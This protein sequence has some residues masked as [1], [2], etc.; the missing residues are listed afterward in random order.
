M[1]VTYKQGKIM[2]NIYKS[3]ALLCMGLAATACIEENFENNGP[4][5]D[6]TPG[7]EIVF[8]ATTGVED[9]DIKTRTVYGNSELTDKENGTGQQGLIEVNWIEGDMISIVSPQA[10]GADVAHFEVIADDDNIND[11]QGAHSAK[12]LK[13]IGD[14]GLQW[15]DS[16]AFDFYAV[17]PTV[18]NKSN[19]SLTKEGVF[20]GSL[21]REQTFI[22]NDLVDAVDGEGNK[23]K[24]APP[25]MQYAFMTAVGNY[26]RPEEGKSDSPINLS[27]SS[28]MTALQFDVTAGEI[29]NYVDEVTK[30]SVKSI[31]IVSISLISNSN[32][33]YGSFEYDFRE[34]VGDRYRSTT[35]GQGSANRIIMHF[36]ETP[37]TLEPK[38]FLDVT[39]FLLPE[40]I[41]A[42]DLTLQII[43]KLG[44]T[45]MS[46]SAVINQALLGGKKYRFEDVK[47]EDFEENINAGS[48]FDTID[49]STYLSQLSI[50]VASN[51]F[52]TKANGFA[53]K[54]L[55]QALDLDALWQLGVR[56]FELV[57][58]RTV[59]ITT[60][61][62]QKRYS[63]NND[64]S[65]A[66]AHFVCD[67]V[68]KE[69][70][71][72][73]GIDTFGEAFETLIAKL[74]ANPKEFLAIIC[75]YQ[76]IN[77]GYDPNGYVK[78]LLNYLDGLVSSKKV[79]KNRFIKIT[80]ETTVADAQGSIAIIIRPGDDDRYETNSYTSGISLESTAG[81]DWSGEV[82]L[83]QDWGTAFD[84]WDR[85]YDGVARESTFETLYVVEKAKKSTTPRTQIEDWLWGVGS[86]A[87]G[88]FTVYDTSVHNFNSGEKM[89]NKKTQFNYEHAITGSTGKAYVQEWARVAETNIKTYVNKEDNG[90][91]M[92]V[93]W[94]ES[95]TDKKKAID[96]LFMQSVATLGTSSNN[97]YIN[98]LSGYYIAQNIIEGL[99]PFKEE[100]PTGRM[101]G[102]FG[103]TPQYFSVSNQGKGGEHQK[104]AYDLNKYV[105]EILSGASNLTV[106]TP[107]EGKLSQ[108]PWGLVMME[109]IGSDYAQDDMSIEL[110]D[111]IIMNNFKLELD[112]ADKTRTTYNATYSNGGEAISFK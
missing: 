11:F 63:T 15:S 54:S 108:G 48:W 14:A 37:V 59:E 57:N 73:A 2:K 32:N 49:P 40:Q 44:S 17:Y 85:R 71:T 102:L 13:R 106:T 81:E 70:V 80:D 10:A 95:I 26:T 28:L 110:V 43:F 89:P 5:Y 78:Q 96:G 16:P 47:L 93:D 62:G 50:P 33:I 107:Q 75:T 97:L 67:E 53:D 65:L 91:Y 9:N 6:T 46:R 12:E 58:R 82:T 34:E 101:G 35:T 74:D 64:W 103:N 66:N 38:Q 7:N 22:G 111:L 77:D 88:D 61:W 72:D 55:Q 25:N 45:T 3:F 90:R 29:T 51:V 87:T 112:K 18:L 94:P 19:S 98:S 30:E 39:F 36:E 24:I 1:G 104:L 109:H 69:D 100:F 8:T 21:P 4:K 92:W 83:I 105:Y 60:S 27:F 79:S 99:Y 68:P 42:G 76:A 31:D 56:G 84:V 52:A 86:S 23:G 20:T 41:A